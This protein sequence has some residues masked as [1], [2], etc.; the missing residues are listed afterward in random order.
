MLNGI[1]DQ[2]IVPL[3]LHSGE[4]NH[5]KNGDSHKSIS[6]SLLNLHGITLDWLS[7]IRIPVC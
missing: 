3:K 7:W 2:N 5:K 1:L 6:G 4:E